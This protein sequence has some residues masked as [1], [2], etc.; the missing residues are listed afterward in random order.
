M[1]SVVERAQH[2]PDDLKNSNETVIAD[3]L[4]TPALAAQGLSF[5][6]TCSGIKYAAFSEDYFIS[7]W[8]DQT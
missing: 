5:I 4:L 8:L 1:V 3:P 2:E 6:K 7:I